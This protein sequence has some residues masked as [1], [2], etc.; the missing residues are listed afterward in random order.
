MWFAAPSMISAVP[1]VPSIH[2]YFY[3]SLHSHA[4]YK[5]VCM[6]RR[7]QIPWRW[8]ESGQD[9]NPSW[10]VLR[11]L[12]GADPWRFIDSN[13]DLIPPWYGLRDSTEVEVEGST[14]LARCRVS[15]VSHSQT[16][17]TASMG[18]LLSVIES[19]ILLVK[20]NFDKL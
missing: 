17:S 9:S 1:I 18:D 11:D 5:S 4:N 3:L 20:T 15:S 16:S 10:C 14:L 2:C 19:I 12:I 7:G 6:C 13:Q 8:K